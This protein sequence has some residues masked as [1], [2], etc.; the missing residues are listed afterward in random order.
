MKQ[1][2]SSFSLLTDNAACTQEA[3][4][5]ADEWKIMLMRKVAWAILFAYSLMLLKPAVPVFADVVAHTFWEQQHMLT[6]HEVHGKFHVHYESI[7]VSGQGGQ[8]KHN[9]NIKAETEDQLYV[10]PALAQHYIYFASVP[11]IIYPALLCS[12]AMPPAGMTYPPPK[13]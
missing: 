11:G 9:G 13:A 5:N 4:A 10:L 8:Q 12:I 7:K 3:E 6:V 1:F 2:F